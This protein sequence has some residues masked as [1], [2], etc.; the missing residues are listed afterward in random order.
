[1]E[2]EK[3]DEIKEELK[4]AIDLVKDVDNELKP[5]AFKYVLKRM[6]INSNP[7]P[8]ISQRQG[9]NEDQETKQPEPTTFYEKVSKETGIKIEL[10]EALVGYDEG[11]NTFKLKISFTRGKEAEK[12]VDASLV[13][14]TLKK[15]GL[16]NGSATSRELREMLGNL[17]ISSLSNFAA[18]MSSKGN[19]F[20]INGVK[21]SSNMTYLITAIGA[22]KG[23]EILKEKAEGMT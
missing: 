10:L 14:L 15:F 13:Y 1:M 21:G 19:Y 3:L 16:G 23:V 6:L 8:Q 4:N 9:T 17:K 12:Q 22:Q 5:E 7:S 2:S 18:T 20:T 11:N